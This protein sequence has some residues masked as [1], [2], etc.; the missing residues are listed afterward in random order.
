MT[1]E[2]RERNSSKHSVI[3]S[4]IDLGT[5]TT[6]L[7]IDQARNAFSAITHPA[8]AL[9]HV[10]DTMDNLSEAMNTSSHGPKLP[11]ENDLRGAATGKEHLATTSVAPHA[12]HTPAASR[13]AK[14][15]VK[16]LNRRKS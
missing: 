16:K 1:A 2:V 8:E 7:T 11:V 6:K 14:S 5:A 12:A 9:E 15:G 3:G 4:I 10:K 13:H